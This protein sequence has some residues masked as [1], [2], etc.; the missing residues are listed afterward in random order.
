MVVIAG[1]T[2][3]AAAQS[4]GMGQ[5]PIVVADNLTATQVKAYR[6]ADNR[7]GQEAEWDEDLL[8]LELLDLESPDFDLS[9]TGFDDDELAALMADVEDGLTN[10]DD[11]PDA[12]EEPVTVAG[13]VW[14]LGKHRL[15]CA[16]SGD[17]RITSAWGDPDLV[18]TDPPYCSGGFQES[19]RSGGSVGT[20]SKHKQIANDRLSSRGFASLIKAGVFSIPASF[21]Y[22][23]TDWRMWVYL[24]D[25]AESSSA[26]V[27]SMITWNKGSPGMGLGW[28][29]QHEL[30]MWATRKSPPFA[31][32][33][34][35]IGNVISLPR[36]KNELHTTQKPV[37]LIRILLQGAP[38]A[39]TVAD[40]FAGSGTTMI[41][42]EMEGR[43]CVA[44]ELDPIYCDVIVKR[45]CDFTGRDALHAETGEKFDG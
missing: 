8:R 6:L 33:F 23:F 32:G 27:R 19:A 24:F 42:C 10:P 7:V 43:D 12:P 36:Q 38:F 37:E 30:I 17:D 13:D 2:R 14:L 20:A 26:G 22:I 5:V 1:H 41:A 4:L 34:P 40:P 25:A 44:C 16:S 21:F 39:R 35:G 11:V 45:W 3:L 28:R 29:S 9:E 15:M 18:L 31:R